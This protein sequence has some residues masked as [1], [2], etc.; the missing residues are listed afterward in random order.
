MSIKCTRL[1]AERDRLLAIA[2][3]VETEAGRAW[4]IREANRITKV[5]EHY[6]N[7]RAQE[8]EKSTHQEEI[9]Q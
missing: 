9:T 4:I 5:I 6:E 7:K 8:K 2:A 1:R 3:T